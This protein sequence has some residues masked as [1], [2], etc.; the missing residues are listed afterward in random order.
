MDNISYNNCVVSSD[1]AKHHDHYQQHQY[2]EI[3]DNNIPMDLTVCEQFKIAHDYIKKELNS[4]SNCRKSVVN[5]VENQTPNGMDI[6]VAAPAPVAMEQQQVQINSI[7]ENDQVLNESAATPPPKAKKTASKRKINESV[8]PI[9][10]KVYNE[11]EKSTVDVV[12]KDDEDESLHNKKRPKKTN[13]SSTSE[14]VNNKKKVKKT[15]GGGSTTKELKEPKQPKIPKE[16]KMSKGQQQQQNQT[17]DKST[18]D[19][20]KVKS[21]KTTPVNKKKKIISNEDGTANNNNNNNTS[22]ISK[23]TLSSSTLLNSDTS[24]NSDSIENDKEIYLSYTSGNLIC[25]QRRLQ[26]KRNI[27]YSLQIENTNQPIFIIPIFAKKY[28]MLFSYCSNL[29]KMIATVY[30]LEDCYLEIGD[31]CGIES[32]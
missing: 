31:F 29:K 19:E 26:L 9:I 10:S 18:L 22:T 15:I 5:S 1:F 25:V 3:Q 28:N 11:L 27:Q 32:N 4:I 2:Q 17:G 23:N 8:N 24:D 30:V 14:N 21:R 13:G 12:K 16:T 20:P 6:T 7:H